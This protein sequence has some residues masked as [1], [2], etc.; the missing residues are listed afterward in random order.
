[1][2]LVIYEYYTN[3]IL[4]LEYKQASMHAG[5]QAIRQ[6]GKQASRQA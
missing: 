1:M 4:V 3:T 6:A 5:T 2:M